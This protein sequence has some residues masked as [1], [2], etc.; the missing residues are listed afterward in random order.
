MER[1]KPRRLRQIFEK[2]KVGASSEGRYNIVREADKAENCCISH[3]VPGTPFD[4]IRSRIGKCRSGAVRIFLG[5]G[6]HS[7]STGTRI[8][9]QHV[10]LVKLGL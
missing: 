3:R 1:K 4:D 6:I 7:T 9:I 2:Q 5:G 10:F 8:S